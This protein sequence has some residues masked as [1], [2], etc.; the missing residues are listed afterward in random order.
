MAG[1]SLTFDQ[2]LHI[3]AQRDETRAKF[4]RHEH[5]VRAIGIHLDAVDLRFRHACIRQRLEDKGGG[6]SEVAAGFHHQ[7][8][9][10]PARESVERGAVAHPHHSLAARLLVAPQHLAHELASL[11][12]RGKARD[13]FPEIL[14]KKRARKNRILLPGKNLTQTRHQPESAAGSSASASNM[15]RARRSSRGS[16][17]LQLPNEVTNWRRA[18]IC[19]VGI[20]Q[21][22][23][24]KIVVVEMERAGVFIG[25]HPRRLHF[26]PAMLRREHAG[27]EDVEKPMHLCADAFVKMLH[28]MMQPGGEL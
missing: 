20:S 26:V 24:R 1:S 3:P 8:R 19:A 4:L 11:D 16:S 25:E 9:P 28:R 2:F 23:Q 5:P 15:P 27:T 14:Q 12:L 7:R 10:L 6:H 21:S 13:R 18:M 17:K 22:L